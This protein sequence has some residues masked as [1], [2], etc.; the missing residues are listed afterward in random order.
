MPSLGTTTAMLRRLRRQADTAAATS[1]SDSSGLEEI[2]AFGDNPGGLRM[3]AY[4]PANLEPGAPLVV[5][6][7]GCSQTAEAYAIQSGWIALAARLGFAVLAPEQT[8]AGNPNRC[9]NWFS[10]QDTHRGE[11]EA[12]S[13]AAMVEA[14]V[15]T[16]A[17]D[18]R[19]VFVT[20]LSAGG[21]MAAV[22]LAAY[23]DLFAGGA[24]IAGLPYGVA[25]GVME[26]LRVMSHADGRGGEDL[27]NLV[28]RAG[29]G[30]IRSQKL[31]IWHGAN[32]TTVSPTNA[33]DLVAQWASALDLS[34]EPDSRAVIGRRTQSIWCDSRTGEP[35]LELN[36]ISGLGH[37]TP[38][39]TKG[40]EALGIAAPY[41]LDIGISS[42]LE[43][44]RFWNLAP[45]TIGDRA[46]IE[47]PPVSTTARAET[48]PSEGVAGQVL[49]ALSDKVPADIQA[50][51]SKALRAA[52]LLT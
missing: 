20:G 12:A 7:H 50:V 49:A 26:A 9:F 39:A 29:V 44:A 3:L 36:L 14:S 6:L 16:Y 30:G 37:G 5:V 22:M 42:T 41:V 45:A 31:S 47:V 23:P 1:S 35:V 52:G 21:A 48:A 2:A 28:R 24:V 25:H 8:S 46:C 15:R 17:L 13:I 51:I 19:R 18:P 43:I 33:A 32:D 10:A 11:G 4:V 38:I 40:A 34:A 27:A